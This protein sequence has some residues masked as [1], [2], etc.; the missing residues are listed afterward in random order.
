M[1]SFHIRQAKGNDD[2]MTATAG[3]Y[4]KQLKFAPLR[5]QGQPTIKSRNWKSFNRLN[6][7]NT[8]SM[9]AKKILKLQ[10]SP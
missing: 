7:S 3:L 6:Y 1:F 9:F 4:L 5:V 10:K 2:V 8:Y